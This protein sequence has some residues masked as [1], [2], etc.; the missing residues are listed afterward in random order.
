M[1]TPG[2]GVIID[3]MQ[4]APG[5]EPGYRPEHPHEQKSRPAMQFRSSHQAATI[6]CWRAGV[7]ALDWKLQVP[8]LPADVVRQPPQHAQSSVL[9]AAPRQAGRRASAGARYKAA[10]W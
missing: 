3:S 6:L 9:I 8:E 2:G 10:R 4:Q 7:A 1:R 5:A